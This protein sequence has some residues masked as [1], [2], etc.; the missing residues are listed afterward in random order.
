MFK[1]IKGLAKTTFITGAVLGAVAGGAIL[2]AGP[3]RTHA[4][5]G[6]IHTQ[7]LDTIDRHVDEPAIMRHE[8]RKL[9]KEYPKRI[10][11]VRK[12]LAELG[13]QMRQ[14]KQER[15]ISERVVDLAE[16]DL[17]QFQSGVEAVGQNVQR[18]GLRM[19]SVVVENRV[20]SYDLAVSK[21]RQLEQIVIAHR[22]RAADSAHDLTYLD[23]QATRFEEML[24][25]LETERTQFQAQLFQLERQVDS[26]QRNNRLIDLLERRQRTL[27]ECSA[28]DVGSLDQLTGRLNQLRSTQE[29]QLD[30][31]CAERDA[32]DYESMAR[33]QVVEEAVSY[34]N[35]AAA[36]IE[37]DEY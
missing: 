37:G 11:Q 6:R 15:A 2:I 12:D 25:Q 21:V 22:N 29:A 8:L 36:A 4:V 7:V 28:F 1:L 33:S 35:R 10:N 30:V 19:A 20:Y 9:E 17:S 13:E 32:V 23:Q 14:L 3:A 24:V 26:I 18:S 34:P 5:A 31:L 27:D 16:D